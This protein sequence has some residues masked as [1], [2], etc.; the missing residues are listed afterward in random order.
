[1]SSR[2]PDSFADRMEEAS[3]LPAGDALRLEIERTVAGNGSP[4]ATRWND[5][6]TE[7]QSI[8]EALEDV[9]VPADLQR[10]LL[11]IPDSDPATD[12]I[13]EKDEKRPVSRLAW[14]ISAV[15]VIAAGFL[16]LQPRKSNSRLETVALLAVN[17]HLNHADEQNLSVETADPDELASVLSRELP[18]E[19][20]APRLNAEFQLRGGRKCT[21]GA[22]PAALSLWKRG[23]D[24]YSVF[25]FR[26]NDFGIS[27]LPDARFVQLREPAAGGSGAAWVWTRGNYG[28][29]LVGS[30]QSPL[31][32]LSPLTKN[33]RPR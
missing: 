16:L 28:Y 25:Q 17:N 30:S 29:V 1:M 26:R 19:I 8:R 2:N 33:R 9:S 24:E 7:A 31:E 27:P 14:V 13:S 18:F 20:A 22:H 12:L 11:T 6:L 23:R 15:V 10:R 5:L 32:Q 4:E 21:L 3:S